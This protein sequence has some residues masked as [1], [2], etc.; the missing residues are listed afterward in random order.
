VSGAA[1]PGAVASSP[2]EEPA[3][4]WVPDAAVAGSEAKALRPGD[5]PMSA[6]RAPELAAASTVGGAEDDSVG[7]APGGGP[8]NWPGSVDPTSPTG[9]SSEPPPEPS[10]AASARPNCHTTSD[11]ALPGRVNCVDSRSPA[12]TIP[13]GSSS[14]ARYVSL[15]LALASASSRPLASTGTVWP[16]ATR[17][18]SV[19]RTA[20]PL[21]DSPVMSSD[22][23]FSSAPPVAG[24]FVCADETIEA[25]LR[26]PTAKPCT[27]DS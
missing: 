5:G 1:V 17:P 12:P 11:G 8:E 9:D 20:T 2:A 19:S 6:D 3:D 4:D 27:F 24:S 23:D 13:L 7:P 18:L 25:I 16:W 22:D 21:T 14:G 15:M 10:I 26:G